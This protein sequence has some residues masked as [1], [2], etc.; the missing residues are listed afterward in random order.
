M[1]C[2]EMLWSNVITLAERGIR[3]VFESEKKQ[4]PRGKP[5]L[6]MTR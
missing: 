6:R 3:F 5:R 1:L 2:Q 4:I